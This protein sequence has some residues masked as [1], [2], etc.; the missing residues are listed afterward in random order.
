MAWQP[1]M[2]DRPLLTR[3]DNR[4][5]TKWQHEQLRLTWRTH[6]EP[7]AVEHEV[8]A[9]LQPPLNLAGNSA[10]PFAAT[11]SAARRRF[12]DRALLRISPIGG[13]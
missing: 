4:A 7:W 10:H 12:K 13:S 5:L 3:D 8:I 11:V 9:Q 1:V 2:T 6:P